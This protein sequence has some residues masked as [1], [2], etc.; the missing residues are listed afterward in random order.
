MEHPKPVW[1]HISKDLSRTICGKSGN[2]TTDPLRSD[3]PECVRNLI[4]L[5]ESKLKE[6]TQ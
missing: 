4:D 3:C 2:R 1:T 5:L 6:M